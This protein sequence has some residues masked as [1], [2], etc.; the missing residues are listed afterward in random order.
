MERESLWPDSRY[1]VTGNLFGTS[2]PWL[3][4]RRLVGLL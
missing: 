1:R 3:Q 4:P 2:L